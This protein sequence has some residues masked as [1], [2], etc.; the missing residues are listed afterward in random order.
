MKGKDVEALLGPQNSGMSFIP[1]E[2]NPILNFSSL[3][4]VGATDQKGSV[5]SLPHSG[6]MDQN[7]D[8]IPCLCV[9]SASC[10][11]FHD[12]ESVCIGFCPTARSPT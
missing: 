7:W 2:L 1:L 5:I 3:C 12:G 4:D 8:Q 9:L 11:S 6:Q 10:I